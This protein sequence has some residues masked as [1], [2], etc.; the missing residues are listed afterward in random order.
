MILRRVGG[1]QMGATSVSF[2]GGRNAGYRREFRTLSSRVN[3][4][5]DLELTLRHPAVNGNTCLMKSEP[6]QQR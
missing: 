4:R 6:K 5:H 3:A 2:Q 1:V